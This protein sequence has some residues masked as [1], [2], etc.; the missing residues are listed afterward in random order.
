MPW[1]VTVYLCKSNGPALGRASCL[2]ASTHK[3]WT[4]K[5]SWDVAGEASP[6]GL[7]PWLSLIASSCSGLLI[8]LCF[9][10]RA[11]SH[12]FASWC[13]ESEAVPLPFPCLRLSREVS[14]G[15][16]LGSSPPSFSSRSLWSFV[17]KSW[18]K[19][20]TCREVSS[21]PFSTKGLEGSSRSR[22]TPA[23][24]IMLPLVPPGLSLGPLRG[25]KGQ[26]QW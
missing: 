10:T 20:L 16:S 21:I 24:K 1:S 17:C 2:Q 5:G 13:S 7:V 25:G 8:S 9:F 6:L 26:A 23:G 22:A 19:G 15:S 3:H 12:I 4:G 14:K 18:R 11:W